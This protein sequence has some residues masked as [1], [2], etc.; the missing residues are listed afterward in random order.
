M[1]G[2]GRYNVKSTIRMILVQ[3]HLRYAST[4][5]SRNS[6]QIVILTVTVALHAMGNRLSLLQVHRLFLVRIQQRVHLQL[7]V[8]NQHR[9][10]VENQHRDLRRNQRRDQHR[11]RRQNQRKVN[12]R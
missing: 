2:I 11:Y 8:E 1:L 10:Q 6:P 7:L 12:L 4:P 5:R 3:W 9:D